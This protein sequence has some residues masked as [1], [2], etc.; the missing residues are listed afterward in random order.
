MRPARHSG[1][2]SAF[3]LVLT[4]VAAT[5]PTA[6][7]AQEELLQ[8]LQTISAVRL[9]GNHALGDGTLRR[10]MKTRQPSMFPW[11]ERP[12]LRGDFLRSDVAALRELYRHYGFLDAEVDYRIGS[13]RDAEEVEITFL[14]AEGGRSRIGAVE[15]AGVSAIQERDIRKKLWARPGRPFDPAYLQLDTLGIS[16]LYQERGFRPHVIGHF[17]RD[18]L[19]VTVRY[20]VDEGERYRV[21]AVYVIRPEQ[22]YRVNERLV[23]R[24]LVIE[25]GDYYSLTKMRRSQERLYESGL[26]SQVQIGALPDSSHTSVEYEVMV[27]ERPPRWIDA[28]IGSGTEERYLLTGQWGH[29]NILGRGLSGAIGT[30]LSADR[31]GRFQRWRTQLSVLEPWLFGT[32]TRA[33]A[34]PY[35]ELADNR[36]NPAYILHQQNVGFDFQLRREITSRFRVL[37]T[38]K[39]V[40][41]DQEVDLTKAAR[42]TLTPAEQDSVLADF[43]PHYRTNRLELALERDFRDSPFLPTRGSAQ[44]LVGQIAGFR[45][46]SS[47]T[48]L[49]FFSAWYTPLRN[50]MVLA[51]RVRAGVTDPFGEGEPAAAAADPE[52][53]RVPL[54]DRFKT[55]GVNSIRG[56]DENRIP[57]DGGL[58]VLQGNLELRIPSRWK[59]PFLG[60]LGLET[61]LDAGNV[62]PRPRYIKWDQFRP[63]IGRE[64]LGN[65]DVRYSIGFGPRVDLPIGPLRLDVTW[66]FSPAY[67]QPDYGKAVYQFAI[68]PS[69]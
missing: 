42:D 49:E 69:F 32:R 35:Y 43:A 47:F 20:E 14:I 36:E 65:L 62:W 16:I 15:L 57:P 13:K 26:F 60:P 61:Y 63:R 5:I 22:R 27:R 51:S 67:G 3:I 68:G 38:Q 6:A 19:D 50:G 23:R 8:E 56:F 48:K 12:L 25:E 1:A 44:T 4:L 41:V 59:V 24:E 31:F 11:S 66:T 40:I 21:G 45:G 29:R 2:R 28:S 33:Q 64:P 46:S 54:E 10:V 39:N 30:D 53:A 18:S 7:R 34:T 17:A 9:E 58:A 52:V 55:G 37:L